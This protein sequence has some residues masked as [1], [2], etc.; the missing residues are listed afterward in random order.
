[1]KTV[2]LALFRGMWV[3]LLA[4]LLMLPA[5]AL[6]EERPEPVRVGFF[7][8]DGY[9]TIDENG[10]KS[11]YGYEF[12][13]MVSRFIDVDYEYVG[14]ENSWEDMLDML[15][16]GEID[17]VTSARVTQERMDEFAFSKPIGTSSAILTTYPGS[18]IIAEDY[19]T[20]DGIRIGLLKGSSRNDDLKSFAE[21]NGFSYTPMYFELHTELEQALQSGQVDAIMTSSLRQTNNER[22]L[23]YFAVEQFYTMLRKED[24]DLLNRLNYAIDQL[25]S[26]EG[27]WK[28][29]LNN[30]YYFHHEEQ[31]LTF[32]LEEQELIHQYTSGKKSLVVSVCTDKKPYAY[33]ENGEAR[34]ILIDYFTQL[35]EYV[36]IPYT[37]V[38]PADREEYMRWCEELNVANVFLDGRFSSLQQAEERGR[39]I[40]EPYTTMRLAMVTRRD[41]DGRID[42]LAV[43]SA[44][45]LFGIE[46]GL[47]PNAE[48]LTVSSREEAMQAV[49]G[50]KADAT[51]VSLY[52]AQQFVNLDSR[53]LLTYTMLEE[54]TYDYHIAF[55]P[56]LDNALAGIF[57]K[58]I[59]ATPVG[60]FENIASEY[61]SYKAQNVDL[62]TW[63]KIHPI[64]TLGAGALV[65]LI[66]FLIMTVLER[67]KR[68]RLE[69]KR[70]AELEV[71][72]DRAERASRAKSDFLANV[73]H[74]IR[75]PMNAIVG[76]ANLMECDLDDR[77]KI[78]KYLGKIRFSSQHL[79]DLINDVLD[80]SR[81]EADQITLTPEPVSLTE[82]I[83][84]VES[85]VSAAAE[86]RRQV[87]GVSIY[88]LKHDSV[89]ADG[90][91]LRQVLVNLLSNA[92]KYTQEGGTVSLVMRELPCEQAGHACISF[93]VKDN[94]CGIAPELQEHLF[95]PFA[96]GEASVTNKIQGTG[97]GMAITKNLVDRMDGEIAVDSTLGKGT[98]FVVTL[99]FALTSWAGVEEQEGKG[100]L[101]GMRF[102]CAEDN[103]INAEILEAVLET[104]GATCRI[105]PDG[106]KLVEAFENVFPGEY[107]AIL[108][109]IQMPNMNG[110][111]A[112]AAIR[113]SANPLGKTIPI[114]AMTANA[115]E[116]DVRRSL[117]AGMNAHISKPLNVAALEHTVGELCWGR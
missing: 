82:Q 107:N 25:N 33:L 108:M 14:Y 94:G 110:L 92:V 67:Q 61:T 101:Y 38:A 100:T 32:T 31:N 99:T 109:D 7:A 77:D 72:A 51:F 116:E 91:R 36:G 53:G 24:T 16:A 95:E 23:N 3:V 62:A 9:H 41:F 76:F 52:T 47:A 34:G 113:S 40:T 78:H 46:D 59:Y 8:F 60:T 88:G 97:L 75:T 11:G 80:M 65:F 27:D 63:I 55:A 44:Q 2:R 105:Y 89:M 21:E 90:V 4:A 49:L 74:D 85:I 112:A 81:I 22:V 28:N 93:Q 39:A 56:Q 117:E 6:A 19:S 15:R 26:V 17:M 70:S 98:C 87:F 20:Y 84:L 12:L 30:K 50:G 48:R 104:H 79:L 5:T 68:I 37:I 64:Y 69:Q 10:V 29:D 83:R 42:T 58:A 111:E 1:M 73:S 96:R 114:I 86:E 45:G 103:E 13:R 102:L 106:E 115:F 54:P 57:T 71:L 35:A 18:S 43:S 66:C